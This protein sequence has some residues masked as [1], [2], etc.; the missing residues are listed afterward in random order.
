MKNSKL[1]L[2]LLGITIGL[3]ALLIGTD[4]SMSIYSIHVA[5]NDLDIRDLQ[6][7]VSG[8]EVYVPDMGI[9]KWPVEK[10]EVTE[11][12]ITLKYGDEYLVDAFLNFNHERSI[13][14]PGSII[15]RKMT[16]DKNSVLNLTMKYKVN[17]LQK[18]FNQLIRLED[19]LVKN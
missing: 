10:A 16:I 8:D 5:N 6:L 9:I 1:I 18:E 4:N 14:I 15:V 3:L 11:V 12:M 19:Y 13:I 7:I 17:G 2:V